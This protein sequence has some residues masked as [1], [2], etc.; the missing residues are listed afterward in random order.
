MESLLL[1][2]ESAS[3]NLELVLH[4]IPDTL[5]ESISNGKFVSLCEREFKALDKE[6]RGELTSDDLLDVI[7]PA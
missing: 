3:N 7:A 5:R 1:T 2:L 4:L 6:E